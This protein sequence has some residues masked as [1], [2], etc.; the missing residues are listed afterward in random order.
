MLSVVLGVVL[1]VVLVR[2]VVVDI[3]GKKAVL[4]DS[5]RLVLKVGKCLSSA[6]FPREVLSQSLL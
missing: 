1:V 4:V 3:R 5:I 2:H 6:A